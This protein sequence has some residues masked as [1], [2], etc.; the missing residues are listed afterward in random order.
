MPQCTPAQH[1]KK[2]NKDSALSDSLTEQQ[3]SCLFLESKM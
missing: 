2:V 1:N 3:K